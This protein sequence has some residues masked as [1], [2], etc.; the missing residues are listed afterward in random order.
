VEHARYDVSDP[1]HP[2]ETG[3]VRIGGIVGRRPHPARPDLPLAGGPQMVEVSRD[4]RRVYFT[5]S[6][7]GSWDDEFCHGGIGAWIPEAPV[8]AYAFTQVDRQV[9][10]GNRGRTAS[11][12]S[13]AAWPFQI[14]TALAWRDGTAVRIA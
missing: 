4:S 13:P 6:L 12:R 3:S 9:T 1:F 8:P 7:Y 5:N 2:V 14:R 10:S 11:H